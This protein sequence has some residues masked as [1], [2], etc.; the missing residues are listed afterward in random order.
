MLKFTVFFKM[1]VQIWF[2]FYF[3]YFLSWQRHVQRWL[4]RVPEK[5][6]KNK[7]IFHNI[8]TNLWPANVMSNYRD[9]VLKLH[10]KTSLLYTRPDIFATCFGAGGGRNNREAPWLYYYKVYYSWPVAISTREG[11]GYSARVKFMVWSRARVV[12]S[13]R[14]NAACTILT[15]FRYTPKEGGRV[16]EH[17]SN[18]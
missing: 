1:K 11:R 13:Q 4:L 10:S 3:F 6:N 2:Y 18:E 9:A 8:M 16:E 14:W 15:I 5:E 12:A 17:L 7:N